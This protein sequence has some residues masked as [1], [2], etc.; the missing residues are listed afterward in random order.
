M[1]IDSKIVFGNYLCFICVN[2]WLKE[3]SRALRN[4][5]AG[6]NRIA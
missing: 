3:F 5:H 1:D 4:V 2:L 6:N